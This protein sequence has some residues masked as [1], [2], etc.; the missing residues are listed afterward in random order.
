MSGLSARH[1]GACRCREKR[2]DSAVTKCGVKHARR[3]VSSV[4]VLTSVSVVDTYIMLWDALSLNS[5]NS[6]CV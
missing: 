5:L 1:D 4:A 2:G 3:G 6:A